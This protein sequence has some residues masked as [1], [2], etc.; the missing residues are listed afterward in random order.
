MENAVA[1]LDVLLLLLLLV[2]LVFRLILWSLKSPGG[3]DDGRQNIC[4]K[5]KIMTQRSRRRSRQGRQEGC[6]KV[7]VGIE[8]TLTSTVSLACRRAM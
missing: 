2:L 1:A 4:T 8:L 6:F 3:E 7:C 5:D